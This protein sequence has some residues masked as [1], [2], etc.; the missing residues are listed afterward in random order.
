MGDIALDRLD[1]VGDQVV[2]PLELDVDLAEGVLEPVPHRHQ[3]VIRPR[4]PE[5]D[6]HHDEGHDAQDYRKSRH[7]WIFLVLEGNRP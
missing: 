5:Q 6:G 2:P 1:Q 4:H 7:G 3:A